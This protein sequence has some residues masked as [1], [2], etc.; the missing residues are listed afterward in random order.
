[1]AGQQSR[2]AY[3]QPANTKVLLSRPPT[4]PLIRSVVSFASGLN[5]SH[6]PN[7]AFLHEHVG[8]TAKAQRI[9][10]D[11]FISCPTLHA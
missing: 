9:V 4:F 6:Q 11:P 5:L 8:R 7:Q 10:I 2:W 1:M 3:H